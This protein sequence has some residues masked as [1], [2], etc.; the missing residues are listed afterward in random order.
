MSWDR[1]HKKTVGV[2]RREARARTGTTKNAST[3][4][5]ASDRRLFFS[6][7][8]IR[9]FQSA[10]HRIFCHLAHT[11]PNA[12]HDGRILQCPTNNEIRRRGLERR[13]GHVPMYSG[14]LLRRPRLPKASTSF[15]VARLPWSRERGALLSNGRC[16]GLVGKCRPL[17]WRRARPPRSNVSDLQHDVRSPP[18]SLA[19]SCTCDTRGLGTQRWVVLLL[20]AA[21]A[22]LLAAVT[23]LALCY[24][25]WV[26]G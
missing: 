1:G 11:T 22:S 2:R 6:S 5:A 15:E 7:T 3:L 8:F 18:D 24:C 13:P 21:M 14:L 4:H 16:R 20:V 10:P 23:W 17:P 9:S 19:S 26:F 12:T 25:R